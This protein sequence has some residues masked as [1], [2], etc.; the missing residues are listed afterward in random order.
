MNKFIIGTANFGMDYGYVNSGKKLSSETVQDILDFAWKNDIKNIDTAEGYGGSE[1]IIGNYLINNPKNDF[2]V[3][4]K[5][6]S[7]NNLPEQLNQSL[8]NLHREKVYGV[9]IHSFEH[10]KTDPAIFNHFLKFKKKGKSTKVGFSLYYPDDLQYLIDNK[11]KF[12]FIQ[13]AYSI[14]DRRFEKF[15]PILKELGVEIHVRSIFLQGLFFIN[16]TELSSHFNHV[17]HKLKTIQN[18]SES[19]GL[20]LVSICINFVLANKHIDKI[21]IGVDSLEN[22]KNNIKGLS[23]FDK[24]QPHIEVLNRLSENDINILFP[25]YWKV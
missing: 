10:F 8:I 6:L 23:D 2:N 21:I 5:I 1:G 18:L 20:S 25:H 11:I 15:F 22:L 16:P 3:I 14:F 19:I 9:L 13:V 12:D 17:K 7:T 4:T 24:L